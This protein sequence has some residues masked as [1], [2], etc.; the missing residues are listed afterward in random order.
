MFIAFSLF[1]FPEVPKWSF[2]SILEAFGGPL[3]SLRAP[4]GATNA[5][6][7]PSWRP[8]GDHFGFLWRPMGFSWLSW[9]DFGQN[10]MSYS[11]PN[12]AQ[13]MI[14]MVSESK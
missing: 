8:F 1:V 13:V 11:C 9:D 2:R 14:L 10:L 5:L 12:Q 6:W 4:F 3:G 7:W